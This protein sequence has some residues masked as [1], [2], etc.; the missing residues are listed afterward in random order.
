MSRRLHQ[1]LTNAPTKKA[2]NILL[3]RLTDARK[4]GDAGGANAYRALA[5]GICSEFRKLVERS[6]EEDLLNKVVLRHRRGIQTDG[7]LRA[8]QG[9]LVE[10]C[11]LIDELMTKYSCYEHSQSTEI[12]MIIPEEAE[13]RADLEALSTWREQLHKRRAA[14]V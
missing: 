13:L 10:D 9:I 6:V 7:R 8:I 12:P 5:Q 4:A 3:N 14:A 11:R 2:N 1:A